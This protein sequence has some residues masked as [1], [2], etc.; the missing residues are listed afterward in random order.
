MNLFGNEILTRHPSPCA[1]P[2]GGSRQWDGAVR[3]RLFTCLLNTEHCCQF[4]WRGVAW[5]AVQVQQQKH[6]IDSTPIPAPCLAP[7]SPLSQE[8]AAV[9]GVQKA[10]EQHW[11]ICT[12]S[13]ITTVFGDKAGDYQTGRTVSNIHIVS[14]QGFPLAK[15]N[16][17]L[18]SLHKPC[19]FPIST[20]PPGGLGREEGRDVQPK[21]LALKEWASW[22]LPRFTG[23]PI[24]SS[25]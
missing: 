12:A 7:H 1:L 11:A 17:P 19:T 21:V 22:M 3:V 24:Y 2:L 10:G 15:Q 5:G 4:W 20:G 18:H 16:F 23:S 14:A 9:L 13:L 6:Q 8:Q 25:L